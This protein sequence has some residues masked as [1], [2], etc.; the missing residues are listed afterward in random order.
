VEKHVLVLS[1]TWISE[2]EKTKT[3]LKS[4]TDTQDSYIR[5]R[6]YHRIS[7][8]IVDLKIYIRRK[9]FKS[10]EI[11]HLIL[12]FCSIFQKSTRF[13]YI[14]WM[15]NNLAC[16]LVYTGICLTLATNWFK[17]ILNLGINLC[18]RMLLLLILFV[19]VFVLERVLIDFFYVII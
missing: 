5:L 15:L 8:F 16:I 7:I 12:Y 19:L 3:R 10:Y 17:W 2:K 4:S 14:M 13:S 18:D 1:S 6:W 11:K 9:K